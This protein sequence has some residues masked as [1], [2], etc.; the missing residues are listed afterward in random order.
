MGDFKVHKW[1]IFHFEYVIFLSFLAAISCLRHSPAQLPTDLT[2][3]AFVRISGQIY[4]Q[5]IILGT[6]G[7]QATLILTVWL[8]CSTFQLLT[9]RTAY[10][11]LCSS[12]L[13]PV[14]VLPSCFSFQYSVSVVLV[15]SFSTAM[16]FQNTCILFFRHFS[17][18]H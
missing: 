4:T 10:D 11:H 6:N 8:K 14:S 5:N 9:M 16:D 1:R 13:L 2:L 15:P 7:S 18:A 12:L 17:H 3:G